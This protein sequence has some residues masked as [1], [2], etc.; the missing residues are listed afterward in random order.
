MNSLVA[1]GGSAIRSNPNQLHETEEEGTLALIAREG[2]R[3]A[4]VGPRLWEPACGRGRMSRVF[5]QAGFDVVS[6]DLVDRGFGTGGVDF[7]CCESLRAPVIVT[8]P[9]YGPLVAAFISHAYALGADML[10]LLIK[11]DW[12][13]ATGKDR[14]HE[15]FAARPPSRIHPVGFRLDWTGQGRPVMNCIWAV[16][17]WRSG[18]SR[19]PL[20]E[21]NTGLGGRPYAQLYAAVSREEAL[22]ARGFHIRRAS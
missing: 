10:A 9:P 18:L 6:T 3:M 12:F 1:R 2:R 21:P 17:D 19:V 14:R 5:M 4:H 13:H 8:N 7:L 20:N 16:W 15:L 22:A 11:A